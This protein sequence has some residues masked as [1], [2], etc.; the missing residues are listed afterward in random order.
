M[1]SKVLFVDRTN[2]AKVGMIYFR[3][4]EEYEQYKKQEKR[5]CAVE[6][7]EYFKAT[8][9]EAKEQ[10]LDSLYRKRKQL[11]RS[12]GYNP[13]PSNKYKYMKVEQYA[14]EGEQ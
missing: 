3:T 5:A 9:Q 12:M 13:N 11:A 1:K 7:G 14:Q 8:T 4:N 2:Q 6:V 10:A